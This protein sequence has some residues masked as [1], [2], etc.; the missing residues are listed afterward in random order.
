MLII[1]NF[2]YR[3][4]IKQDEAKRI[5]DNIKE[6]NEKSKQERKA[7]NMEKSTQ[8][9][10]E[11]MSE[12]S[13]VMRMTMKPMIVSFI[14]VIIFLPWLASVYGDSLVPINNNTGNFTIDGKTYGVIKDGSNVK[15]NELN[16][17]CATPCIQKIDKFNWKI[18]S[19]NNNVKFARVLVTLPI[20]L[21]IFGAYLGWLGWYILASI[22]IMIIIRKL[23]KINV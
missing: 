21:P 5:K 10:K 15:L 17:D 14:I 19:E 18:T 20:P 23:L 3:I 13:K 6:L 11:A 12:N 9:M 4:L 8:Y 7:G 22:P 1:I 2:F 16:I